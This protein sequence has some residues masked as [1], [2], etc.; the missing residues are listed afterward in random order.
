M[1]NHC[2]SKTN[3]LL[4]YFLFLIFIISYISCL[5]RTDKKDDIGDESKLTN[6]SFKKKEHNFGEIPLGVSVSTLFKFSN[7]GGKPLLIS[8]VTS[9]C[10]CTVPTWSK[11]IIK[12]YESGEIKIIYDAK[13]PGK[14]NK[15]IWVV[16][17]GKNSPLELII[18]GEVPYPKRRKHP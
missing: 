3:I 13:Y 17:N 4:R 11:G 1:S 15:T 14:F 6:I 16:Y 12:P 18:K 9:S 8:R 10:G 5:S 2:N 7:T